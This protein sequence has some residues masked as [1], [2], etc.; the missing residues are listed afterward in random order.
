MIAE[1][2]K[3]DRQERKKRPR[4]LSNHIVSRNYRPPEIILLDKHYDAGIDIWSAGCIFAELLI[5]VLSDKK[6]KDK[7]KIIF[8]GASCYPL[9]PKQKIVSSNQA[10]DPDE[11][12]G[13]SSRDQLKYICRVIG[14]PTEN[15]RSFISDESAFEYLEIAL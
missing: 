1:K 15:D 10:E 9:S 6:L 11:D 12:I 13:I 2:L 8:P 7:E 14:T 3:N 5:C 4:A